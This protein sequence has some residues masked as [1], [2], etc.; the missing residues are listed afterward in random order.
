MDRRTLGRTGH[1][2]VRLGIGTWGMAGED[3]RDSD[4][5]AAQRTLYQ[6]LDAGVNFIDTA[7]SDGDGTN[8]QLIGEVIRDQRAHDS[9][10]LAT[11]V[12][13]LDRTWSGDGKKPLPTIFPA[14]YVV[15][16][17]ETSLRNLRA[18]ALGVAQLRGWH[19][20]WLGSTAW[21]ELRGTM[22]LLVKQGKVRYWGIS[23]NAHDPGSALRVLDEPVIA[24]VQAIYNIFDQ[25]SATE[26][27]ARARA[28]DIGVIARRPFDEGGLTGTLAL[29][30][31]F[32][33][34]DFR[35][36]YFAGERLA[37]A[38]ARA[39]KL[40]Q[41]C[42]DEIENLAEMAL[43]FALSQPDVDVVIAG[44]RQP[45]HLV[46]NLAAAGRGPLS[47]ALQDRLGE[48]TWD[49]NWYRPAG[50]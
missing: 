11:K 47:A 17:V 50:P 46:A 48:E 7:L 49:R 45:D 33:P 16:S 10:L 44:M 12:P 27:F 41:L 26:L 5:R 32:A 40:S 13:P 2:V 14:G 36:D 1:A 4:P 15:R 29:T 24:T 34:G 6:A 20:S 42:G 9:V 25:S 30:T 22:E 23:V 19:D 38:I 21:P 31:R 37:Q 39:K 18:E 3:W 8:E 35:S 43:R 28:N